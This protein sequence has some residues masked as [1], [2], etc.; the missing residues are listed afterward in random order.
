MVEVGRGLG[1]VV[2]S[3][4]DY[5]VWGSVGSAPSGIRGEVP[6]A[7][8]FSAYSRPYSDAEPIGSVLFL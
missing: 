1:R 7:K 8:A 6:D 2:S 4:P 3:P 5:G